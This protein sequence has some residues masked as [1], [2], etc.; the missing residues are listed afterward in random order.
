MFS[1]SVGVYQRKLGG[2]ALFAAE[3]RDAVVTDELVKMLLLELVEEKA[4]KGK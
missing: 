1:L 3:T 4:V 2:L